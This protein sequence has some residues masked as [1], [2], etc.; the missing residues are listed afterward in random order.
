MTV[1]HPPRLATALLR[2]AFDPD[3]PLVGDLLEGF[4]RNHSRF[5]FWRQTISALA[6]RTRRVR[7][8]EH[9]LG[10][11]PPAHFVGA[12]ARTTPRPMRSI[13]LTASP[14]MHV[15]GLG[16]VIFVTLTAVVSPQ[17]WWM[18][19]PAIAGGV[20]IGVLMVIARRP[21]A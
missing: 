6:F 7:D 4:E 19:V 18:F 1:S 17:A 15:G 8:E 12:H 11:A 2:R 9:P 14:L 5:W 20:V 16:L 10:L 13:D 3:E 21:R